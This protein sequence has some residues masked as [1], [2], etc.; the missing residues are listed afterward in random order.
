MKKTA[1]I[2]LG[3]DENAY[4][5]ARAFY[6]LTGERPLLLC[7]KK[8]LATDHSKILLRCKIDDLDSASVF[9]VIMKR[10]LSDARKKADKVLVIPCS[11]YYAE[12]IINSDEEI[13]N[14][15]DN[16]L[17]SAE[18]YRTFSTKSAF[19]VLCKNLGVAHPKTEITYPASVLSVGYEG[20]FPLVMK[21][22][23]SNF[24]DYL[25]L[26]EDK[27]K[28]VYVCRNRDQLREACERLFNA[29]YSKSVVLQ[30]YIDGDEE[31]SAVINAY[32]DADSNVRVIG[33]AKPLLE[34]K[35]PQK[36]GNY[37]AL[38]SVGD[39]ELCNVAA[40]ILKRIGY[41]G[42]AN[43][44]LKYDRKNERYCFLE[45]NPRQGRSSFWLNC[46]GADL[47]AS[48]FA[49]VVL[50]EPYSETVYADEPCLWTNEPMAVINRERK[51]RGMDPINTE[52]VPRNAFSLFHD[53]SIPRAITLAKRSLSSFIRPI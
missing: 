30:E 36:I 39:R 18:L 22:A 34:Y 1:V 42:F 10:V 16:P 12:L 31:T 6:G 17:P 49:D 11:D 2:I 9:A 50:G 52:L 33:L 46:A 38:Q 24:S 3:S 43:I 27:R 44:D 47:M 53:L 48:M 28:K 35:D 23:N 15:I 20:E 14:M 8:L 7:S 21:P 4:G 26:E 40:G 29:G 13:R 19:A 5:C 32:C 25:H 41:V 37:A 45:L 51:R